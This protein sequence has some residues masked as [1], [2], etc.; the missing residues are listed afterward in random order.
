MGRY[1]TL[2]EEHGSFAAAA[3]A[4]GIPKSTFRD[5]YVAE[6]DGKTVSSSRKSKKREHGGLNREQLL[7]RHSIEHQIKH[8]A[9]QLVEGEF[10]PEPEFIRDNVTGSSGYKHIVERE[11]FERYRGR[12]SGSVIYWSHPASIKEMKEQ[13]V[14][15]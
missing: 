2:Y 15:R 5:G 12:A 13:H 3:R 9:D 7:L 1:A 11:E 4:L 6:I 14:L 10:V 8:A